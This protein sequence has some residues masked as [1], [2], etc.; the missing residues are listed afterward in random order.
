MSPL[1]GS[2][3]RR[4]KPATQLNIC[5]ANRISP[6]ELHAFPPAVVPVVPLWLKHY[7]SSRNGVR[8][9]SRGKR[10]LVSAVRGGG[11]SAPSA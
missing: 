7:G 9:A 5:G 2:E 1:R 8:S 6:F 3:T 4:W 10:R 11:L